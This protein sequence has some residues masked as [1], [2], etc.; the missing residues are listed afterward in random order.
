MKLSLDWTSVRP[1]SRKGRRLFL[2]ATAVTFAALAVHL[3]Q[4]SM[5]MQRMLLLLGGTLLFGGVL[6]WW[7]LRGLR[8]RLKAHMESARL[9]AIVAS[10]GDAI[11]GQSLRGIVE[12]WNPAAERLLG[13]SESRAAGQ[14]LA[15]LL[16]PDGKEESFEAMQQSL[17][18]GNT[19][20]PI[21]VHRRS[22]KSPTQ[23]IFISSSP[24]RAPDGS[25]AG[26]AT[27]LRDV[28]AQETAKT[29]LLAW[30]A[31]LERQVAERTKEIEAVSELQRAIL[32]NAG[33]AII[34]TDAKGIV[35]LFNRAAQ[36]LLGYAAE[37]IIGKST[38]EIFHLPQEI[39]DREQEM[40]HELGEPIKGLSALGALAKRG[41]SDAREWTYL[42]KNGEAVP[43][44]LTI[45]ALGREEEGI[46]GYIGIA[47][48]LSEQRRVEKALRQLTED[49]L[50]A[51]RAKA[52]FL[53]NM[54]HEIR[55]PMSA[56]LGL[57]GLLERRVQD[58]E[59]R[60][61]VHRIQRAGD[62]LQAI[63]DDI[64]DFSKIE[65]GR[66]E[67]ESA[68]FRLDE[69][70]DNL[71][72]VMGGNAG[73]KDLEL[74]IGPTPPEAARLVGD[75]HRLGQILTNLT[76]NAVKFTERGVVE[77][78]IECLSI[79]EG[80][81]TLR[82]SIRDTGI[83]IPAEKQAGLFSAFSQA[84]SS[85][86]RRFGGT[87][88]GLAISR[89]LVEM[90]DGEIGVES[91]PGEGSTFWFTARFKTRPVSG[92]HDGELAGLKVLVADDNATSLATIAKI[93]ASIGWQV[94]TAEGGEDAVHRVLARHREGRPLEALLL[95]W[96]MPDLDGLAVAAQ[97]RSML[98]EPQQPI[99]L[100]TTAFSKEEPME[101]AG[102][103]SVD[104][105]L[106]KPVTGSSLYEAI[107]EIH[108]RR[109]RLPSQRSAGAKGRLKGVRVAIIDDNETNRDLMRDICE[110]EGAKPILLPDGQAAL[111]G[112]AANP[113]CADIILMD[114]QMPGMDGYETTR[115]LRRH[116]DLAVIP[117]VALS[118]GVLKNEREAAFEAGM[119]DFIPKP[120]KLHELVRVIQRLV[121]ARRMAVQEA[122]D[123]ASIPEATAPQLVD[124]AQGI[125]LWGS[126]TSYRSRLGK[127]AM[128]INATTESIVA[129]IAK[130]ETTQAKFQLHRIRGAAAILGLGRLVE[131]VALLEQSLGEGL[132]ATPSL[133]AL[134]GTL[135]ATRTA[136]EA[137]L[138][139]PSHGQALAVQ[140]DHSISST[141]G[142]LPDR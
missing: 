21:I 47:V 99:I 95:D 88:L 93:S 126:E 37:E 81:A 13:I 122:A 105:V 32:E 16:F 3:G 117:I 91:R 141:P 104:G 33:S 2:A 67:L 70:L 9:G 6:L 59:S 38:P 90:M 77:V 72:T 60:N 109:G 63:I 27:T 100:L 110:S 54:S 116:P 43:V 107:L 68:E 119:D 115:V 139:L 19:P 76:G 53:A 102:Q 114:I 58:A 22:E 136:I 49:A 97:V 29:R 120:F 75:P 113:E 61:L 17:R 50:A 134:T 7:Y 82:F 45:S 39:R 74:S 118:A 18:L 96:K 87:G 106:P 128:E 4:H 34:A 111:E 42:R 94:E 15:S 125:S 23:F 20:P 86:T 84:D 137:V 123:K 65:A 108:R 8:L 48:D 130:Q 44:L 103:P 56:V 83:G 55:T 79:A 28:T 35:T 1:V 64:L 30:N 41:I 131:N 26:I 62:S 78:G 31:D 10:S 127:F 57:A 142:P 133:D 51:G 132:D 135:E 92:R 129:L 14:P 66:L 73:A 40:S 98:P 101:R 138:T 124:M 24:I 12:S 46:V 85:T 5:A 36:T 112:L 121:Y 71:A 140:K 52:D 80:M 89:R 69:V 11:A 25:L